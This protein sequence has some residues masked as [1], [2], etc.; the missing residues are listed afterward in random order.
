M[1]TSLTYLVLVGVMLGFATASA[2]TTVEH[3]TRIDHHSGSVDVRYRGDIQIEQK[4]IGTVA[5][6]GRPSTLRCAWKANMAVTRNA[7]SAAGMMM[8]RQFVRENIA[9]GSR[10]GWCRT[11]KT[12]I[13]KE[14]A[15]RTPNLDRH[16]NEVAQEDRSVLLAELDRLQGSAQPR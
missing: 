12:A 7:N 9:S 13:A 1:E 6:G 4:Q 11:N 16:M 8:S 14:V 2:S 5:P 10:V 3:T 15:A